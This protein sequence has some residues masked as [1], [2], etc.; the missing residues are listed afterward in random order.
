M[1]PGLRER[2][3][4]INYVL[5]SKWGCEDFPLAVG[6]YTF[7]STAQALV[8]VQGRVGDVH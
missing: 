8:S 4:E 7:R 2:E 6:S 1:N 3:R 5:S